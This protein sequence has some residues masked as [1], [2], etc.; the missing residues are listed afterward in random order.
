MDTQEAIDAIREAQQMLFEAIGILENVAMDL[1]DGHAK[2]YIVDQLQILASTD[3]GFLSRDYNL[4][5]WVSDLQ[6]NEE[7]SDGEKD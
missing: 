2:A 3:H 1:H 6:N 5:Q 7:D 4:D